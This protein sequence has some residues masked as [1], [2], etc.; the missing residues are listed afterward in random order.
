MGTSWGVAP[1]CWS[2]VTKCLRVTAAV[3]AR[4]A[5]R[6]Q[7]QTP[8]ATIHDLALE[9]RRDPNQLAHGKLRLLAFDHQ[10]QAALEHQID[11]LLVIVEMNPAALPGL[12]DDLVEPEAADAEP[13]A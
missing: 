6:D 11:L 7:D 9:L 2:Q 4:A 5:E 10:R 8:R 13:A 3:L 1:A 12:H